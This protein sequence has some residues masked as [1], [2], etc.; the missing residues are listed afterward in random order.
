MATGLMSVS[1]WLNFQMQFLPIWTIAMATA[2]THSFLDLEREGAREAC[3]EVDGTLD[4]R[5]G[6]DEI[7]CDDADGERE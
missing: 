7:P 3:R 6:R 1:C 2:T 5:D 4:G